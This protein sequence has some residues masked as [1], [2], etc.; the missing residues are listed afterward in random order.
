M[1]I[2]VDGP[3]GA[4][5]STACRLLAEKLGFTYLDTGS[6]YRAVAWGLL[7]KSVPLEDAAAVT[8]AL[9][10]IPL[11]FS[12]EQRVMVSYFAESKVGEELRNPE[13][14]NWA[15]RVSQIPAVRNYL[16]QW[17][18][19][20]AQKGD[21]VAEGRDM[22]TV[23]FPNAAIKVY[24]TADLETRAHRRLLEYK[25]KNIEVDYFTL[26]AQIR[27]RDRAD[28]ERTL[29]PLRPAPDSVVVDTSKVTVDQVIERLMDIVLRHASFN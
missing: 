7:E 24:L 21:F 20:L 16:M 12:I 10:D 22:T 18:R 3:A 4:G 28:Q 27:D 25:Q 6:M 23:V 19:K 9:A 26:E 2:A 29:A 1:V 15:S 14:S 13:I 17:Q 5:K 8:D 11:R